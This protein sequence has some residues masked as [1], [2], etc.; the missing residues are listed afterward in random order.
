M[1]ILHPQRSIAGRLRMIFAVLFCLCGASPAFAATPPSSPAPWVDELILEVV[2]PPYILSDAVIVLQEDSRFYLPL[3]QMAD[4]LGY[5]VAGDPMAGHAT[6]QDL[7]LDVPKGTLTIRGRTRSLGADDIMTAALYKPSVADIFIAVALAEQIWPA[8]FTVDFSTLRL[9]IDAAEP[10]PFEARLAREKK[11]AAR[12]APRPPPYDPALPYVA[13][14]YRLFSLPVADIETRYR[15]D[16]DENRMSAEA[17]LNGVMDFMGFS[18]RFSA[19]TGFLD[20][21]Y[22]RTDNVRLTATRK[23][24]G[25]D[26]LPLGFREVQL[27]DTRLSPRALIGGGIGGR[28]MM[29]TTRSADNIQDFDRITVEGQA[30]PGW[31]AELYR[32]NELLAYGLVDARGDYRF[33]DVQL[34]AGNNM[35]RVVLYGPQGQ[36]EERT[37]N[38]MIDGTMAR[39]GQFIYEAAA[40]EAGRALFGDRTPAPFAGTG[41]HAYAAYGV[42]KHLTLFGSLARLSAVT[43]AAKADTTEKAEIFAT[44]GAAFTVGGGLAQ[45]ELYATDGGGALDLRYAG[46]FMGLLVNAQQ[47]LYRNF[48][49]PQTGRG[50]A[51]LRG[52]SHLSLHKSSGAFGLQ[53][54]ANHRT[55]DD[56]PAQ[57]TLRARQSW[58]QG[59]VRFTHETSSILQDFSHRR[60]IGQI[61]AATRIRRFNLRGL[62]Q[63]DL[64]P[65]ARLTHAQ[66]EGR[67][68][69][70]Q[71]FSTALTLRHD[72]PE[73]AYGVNAQFGYDFGKVL[74]AL[75]LDW[76]DQRGLQLI[77]RATT[78]LGPYG[79][80][81]A[82][83]ASSRKL[84]AARPVQARLFVD[85]DRD[86][87]YG[88]GDDPL[89]GARIM[90]GS[91]LSAGRSDA[92]GYVTALDGGG[93]RGLT[94]IRIDPA[95]LDDPFLR[96]AGGV[97][98]VAREGRVAFVDLPAIRTGAIDGTV[99][100]ADGAA[101]AGLTL[102]LRDQADRLV[103]T[104][105]TAYDGF[106]SF[107]YVIPGTYVIRP[108]P[109]PDDA[110]RAPFAPLTV[111]VA[112]DDPFAFGHD[113]VFPAPYP[114]ENA[115]DP[116]AKV[117]LPDRFGL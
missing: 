39:P 11:R 62:A 7:T 53:L 80:H 112:D 27:G 20:S 98:T 36:T 109:A 16:Q 49:T 33:P 2:K 116:A 100:H 108:A 60:T 13:N 66:I 99:R 75:D 65:S 32:N 111:T 26:R 25:A 46:R 50:R 110:P 56:I 40:I 117:D 93:P 47:A 72:F 106:Y 38:H 96:P 83:T 82:Y 89:T 71:G 69:H 30:T 52:E 87:V 64:A 55:Y 105:Q 81:G 88:A 67:Y 91:R 35:I 14:D 103:M 77:L 58:G 102:E 22:K 1:F 79:P 29:L 19:V 17:S 42:N 97:N 61:S 68:Y 31:E 45:A 3:L 70:P 21:P 34:L 104:T 101:A 24:Y 6:A 114:S 12:P 54:E 95:S 23:A 90:A 74:T 15:W 5:A 63:Y 18:T 48:E 9:K 78:S 73:R 51:A 84:G 86:G 107:D 10:L 43:P 44:A 41:L 8:R 115:L 59:R 28:G 94:S 92:Q 113:M 4:L 37:E 85:N 76:Q 57:T